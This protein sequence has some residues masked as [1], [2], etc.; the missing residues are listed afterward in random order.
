MSTLKRYQMYIN[1]EWTDAQDGATFTSTN[2]ATGQAWAEVPE[3]SEA[4]V[5]RAVEAAHRA[6]K[7]GPWW[8]DVKTPGG[9]PRS[10]F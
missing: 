4:D 3:A 8:E 7:E 6:F 5:N 1:G 9:Y 10:T 2:P